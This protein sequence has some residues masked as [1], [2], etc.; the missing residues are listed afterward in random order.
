[1]SNGPFEIMHTLLGTFITTKDPI[2]DLGGNIMYPIKVHFPPKYSRE[3][4]FMDKDEAQ[5]WYQALQ[6]VSR[7][8]IFFDHY[9]QKEKIGEG[10]NAEVF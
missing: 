4:Y 5:V 1:M 10:A 8:Y 2:L 3:L 7:S 6:I 9:E